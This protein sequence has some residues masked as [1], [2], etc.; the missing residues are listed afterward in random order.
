M[1]P[2]NVENAYME[3]AKDILIRNNIND[4]K[5]VN[6]S[7]DNRFKCIFTKMNQT[8][9]L[10]EDVAWIVSMPGGFMCG[11]SKMN[12]EMAMKDCISLLIGKR[13]FIKGVC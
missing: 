10:E 7:A 11:Y 2:S 9:I 3:L 13:K 1:N 12:V 5:V 6:I 8:C 4:I